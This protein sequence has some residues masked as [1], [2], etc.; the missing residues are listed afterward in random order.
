MPTVRNASV[1][2][3]VEDD[4]A[5]AAGATLKETNGIARC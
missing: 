1:D 3:K 5:D 2:A 4:A